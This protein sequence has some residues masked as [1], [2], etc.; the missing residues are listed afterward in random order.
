MNFE[1]VD[2]SRG[3]IRLKSKGKH[4][5]VLGEALI[6]S[7]STE[8]SYVVYLNSLKNWEVPLGVYLTEN[9][10]QEVIRTIRKYFHDRSSI[11]H[12]ES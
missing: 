9:E 11:V 4:V 7:S 8:A 3:A 6:A 5:R 12:F 10:R 1:I 2:I